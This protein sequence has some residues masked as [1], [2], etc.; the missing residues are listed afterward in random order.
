[1][2]VVMKGLKPTPELKDELNEILS[3]ISELRTNEKRHLADVGL[4]LNDLSTRLKKVSERA[5]EKH[6]EIRDN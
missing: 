6:A 5:F 3:G 4:I 1:M 2:K